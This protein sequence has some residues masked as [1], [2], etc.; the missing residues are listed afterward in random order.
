MRSKIGQLW[1]LSPAAILFIGDVAVTLAG[2][3]AR[4]WEGEYSE[5]IEANPVAHWLLAKDPYWFLLACGCWL[6]IFSTLSVF[7]HH[8]LAIWL[9]VLIAVAHAIGGGSWFV[10]FGS[11]GWVAAIGYVW[12]ASEMSLRCWRRYGRAIR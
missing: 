5:A 4:Y 12:L 10:R 6:A 11:W 3:S 2:Q 9:T 7:W 8:P 1:L